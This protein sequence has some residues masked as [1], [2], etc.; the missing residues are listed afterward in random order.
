LK[1]T[2]IILLC[3][4]LGGLAVAQALPAPAAS[5]LKA[6]V[7]AEFGVKKLKAKGKKAVLPFGEIDPHLVRIAEWVKQ[8]APGLAG[9]AGVRYGDLFQ[10]NKPQC[11]F[12]L[13]NNVVRL[14][15]EDALKG[16]TVFDQGG[17]RLGTFSNT[18]RYSREGERSYALVFFQFVTPEGILRK[19][20]P[21]LLLDR[22]LVVWE[23]IRERKCLVEPL[24]E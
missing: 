13:T 22:F 12:P 9:E 19:T 18:Y 5:G 2:P 21:D 4:W 17:N 23:D 10:P 1:K 3:L 24:Q 11:L 14:A 15:P 7:L 6:A 20:G 16:L 8:T